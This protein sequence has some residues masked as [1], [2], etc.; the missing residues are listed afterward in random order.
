MGLSI[1]FANPP[2]LPIKPADAPKTAAIKPVAAK[3]AAKL[4]LPFE[5]VEIT[6]K[7]NFNLMGRLYD[8]T[9]RGDDEEAAEAP[10]TKFPLVILLHGLGGNSGDWG[11]LPYDLVT[12]GY[13]VFA[14]DVR[15]HGQSIWTARK[16]RLT[17]RVFEDKDWNA[18]PKDVYEVITYFKE[19][20]EDYP[21]VN[22][23]QVVIMG[24]SM[25]ANAALI[26]GSNISSRIPGAVKSVV[27]I[28]ANSGFRSLKT[29]DAAIT[30]KGPLF[31]SASQGDP[32]TFRDSQAIYRWALGA[33]ALKLYKSPEIGMMLLKSQPDLQAAIVAWIKRQM[34]ALSPAAKK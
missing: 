23:N 18:I 6:T 29:T 2:A 7:D 10:K 30:Y 4:N 33:K 22:P 17:W 25:G 12:S 24:T 26:A 9:Q 31:V 34:P 21:Q 14:M 16:R 13:A 20:A 32:K 28:S 15:G 3:P 5:E 27:L 1:G 8:Q 19:G 11:T